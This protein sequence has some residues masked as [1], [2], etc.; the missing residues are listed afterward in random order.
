MATWLSASED[1]LDI[2]EEATINDSVEED[3][4]VGSISSIPFYS[5]VE[6]TGLSKA[7]W[8]NLEVVLVDDNKVIMAEGICRN[9]HP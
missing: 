5:I 8:V 6:C 9:I 3:H 1:E 4:L 7:S 2:V